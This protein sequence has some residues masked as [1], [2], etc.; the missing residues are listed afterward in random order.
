MPREVPLR[1]K[2]LFSIGEAAIG[3]KNASLG[4]FLL[5]FYADVIKLAP[6]LVGAAIAISRL[7]D[8]VTDPVM[9][10]VSD[11]TQTRWG[12]RRPFVIG[13]AVPLGLAYFLL[14]TPP[15]A[16]GSAGSSCTSSV[17]TCCCSPCYRLRHTLL[18]VGRRAG[19]R[20]S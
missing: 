20:L 7:W 1:T 18:R 5:F 4:Q 17:R 12:R 13:A 2:F 3:I 16:A 9:G 14:F 10:Y 8:A 11:T 19:A 6:A 15:R